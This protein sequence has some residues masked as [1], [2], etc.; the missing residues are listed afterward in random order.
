MVAMKGTGGWSE[1]LADSFIDARERRK[2]FGAKTP[3]EAVKI[4]LKEAKGYVEKYG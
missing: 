2:T 4:A 3:E 1:K